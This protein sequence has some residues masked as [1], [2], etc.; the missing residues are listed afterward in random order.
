MMSKLRMVF[1]ALLVGA[2]AACHSGVKLNDNASKGQVSEQPN[3][4][5]VAPV[6]VDELNNPNSPLAK[7]SVYFDFDSYDVKQ[8]YQ[9]LLQ[10][11]ANYLKSHPER[12]I[13]I[14][15]NTDER[16]TSEYNLA[17]GQKRADAV[18]RTLATFGVPDSQMEAVSLGKEKPQATG[19][20]EAS[21]AQN[22]RADILYQ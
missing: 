9:G 13:L 15:G 3:P 12:H 10:Q 20:D 22:R 4:N 8:E 18:R 21:W 7:R 6:N 19:H 5:A 17:L 11:H 14:Q 16:G 2:L 1:A